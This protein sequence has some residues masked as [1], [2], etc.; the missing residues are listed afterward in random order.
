MH[1]QTKRHARTLVLASLVLASPAALAAGSTDDLVSGISQTA[2]TVANTTG[3]FLGDTALTTQVRAALLEDKQVP[4]LHIAVSTKDRVVT[5]S[6]SVETQQQAWR[7]A[8]T[9]SKVPGVKLVDNQLA[10][11]PEHDATGKKIEHAV[12][13]LSDAAITSQIKAMLLAARDVPSSRI[14]VHTEDGVVTLSGYVGDKSQAE[15]AANIA[16]SVKDVKEVKNALE[17]L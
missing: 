7:A 12:A 5:L 16:R 13:Y 2:S 6:G 1:M 8:E 9:A 10:I 4:S 14:S 15:R 11:Q 3:R 17:V